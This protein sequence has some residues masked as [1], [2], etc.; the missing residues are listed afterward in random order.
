MTLSPL[1]KS[2][3]RYDSSQRCARQKRTPL[4]SGASACY[5]RLATETGR[6]SQPARAL[7]EQTVTMATLSRPSQAALQKNAPVLNIDEPS[8]QALVTSVDKGRKDL[9][10]SPKSGQPND[11]PPTTRHTRDHVLLSETEATEA[12]PS[13]NNTDCRGPS[14]AGRIFDVF[15]EYEKG[16]G[17][18]LPPE[19]LRS[20][21]QDSMLS[22]AVN[23]P[24]EALP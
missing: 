12:G 8:T 23:Q 13:H 15:A 4:I 21:A 10:I 7:V 20:R 11:P 17:K 18:S 19:T 2:S 14:S 5:T 16:F 22:A 1:N 6:A 9:D 24:Q 3:R